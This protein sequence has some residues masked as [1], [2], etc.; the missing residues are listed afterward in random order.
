MSTDDSYDCSDV[1]AAIQDGR[2]DAPEVQAHAAT[3]EACAELVASPELSTLLED[4][5]PP[6]P[7]SDDLMAAITRQVAQESAPRPRSHRLGAVVLGLVGVSLLFG[8]ARPRPDLA[9]V[10]VQTVPLALAWGVTAAVGLWLVARPPWT[11]PLGRTRRTLALVA[12]WALPALALV[13]P[14]GTP[15]GL[16][17]LE[18]P[19]IA[20]LGYGSVMVVL[21]VGVLATTFR[22][23][24]LL[25]ARWPVAAATGAVL[26]NVSLLVH[27]P[28]P[29]PGHLLVGHVGLGLLAAAA[30]AVGSALSLTPSGAAR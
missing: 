6:E 28:S 12:L 3:C 17:P 10:W 15:L 5:D 1:L 22:H 19:T 7:L 4:Q 25:G 27:C 23:D 26:G 30:A 8:L 14:V 29:D 21:S 18:L 20:C 9:Q 24:T 2:A 13:L 16:G 11:S